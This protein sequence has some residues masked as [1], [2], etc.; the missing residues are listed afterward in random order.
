M[1]ELTSR[2]A[3]GTPEAGMR[4]EVKLVRQLA[5][6]G[7]ERLCHRSS[8]DRLQWP[9]TL[10]CRR[11]PETEAIRRTRHLPRGFRQRW[12]AAA[13]PGLKPK[14]GHERSTARYQMSRARPSSF[15]SAW[16]YR[17]WTEGDAAVSDPS[18]MDRGFSR[19]LIR[20]R[21]SLWSRAVS[22]THLDVY[23]RQPQTGSIWMCRIPRRKTSASW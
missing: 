16:L 11:N 10:A 2:V 7:F 9:S 15:N 21:R 13:A 8:A 22:Y 6:R 17:G 18:L 12:K 20:P 19:R 14:K 3:D 5:L 23:K 1:V 4:I